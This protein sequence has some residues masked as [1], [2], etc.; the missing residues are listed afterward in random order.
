[1][2]PISEPSLTDR[3]RQY[4]LEAFD[5]GWISSRGEFVERAEALLRNATSARYAA[6]VSNGTVALHLA[7]LAAGVEAG[8]EV[9]MPSLSYV[10]TMNAA[11]YIGARPVLV[12]VDP[13]T[14]CVDP[15]AVAAAITDRTRAVIAV[16]LYGNPAD[17][18]A[19]R[20]VTASRGIVLI[21]D[22]AESIGGAMN[23]VPTGA[24]ADISIFSF[25]GN[26]IV[27]SGEGGAVTTDDPEIDARIRQLRNQ[28]NSVERRYFHDVLGFNYRM[29]NLAAAILCAQL[30]RLEE[31]TTHRRE[32]LDWYE[33]RLKGVAGVR[34]QSVAADV[35]RSPWLM[36][37]CVDDWSGAQRDQA[38]SLLA[39][40]GVET[41]PSFVP[42]QDMPYVKTPER[43]S[44]PISAKIGREG[45]SLPT[46]PG[47]TK[48]QVDHICERLLAAVRG[49][50]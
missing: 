18:A 3:E 46:F 36:T 44:T 15:H 5:S 19:L 34:L 49:L 8:D 33:S 40:E 42:M 17:Y 20:N 14:W 25:F 29:T 16:D 47:L 22:A 27:T 9:V 12:D 43:I 35:V 45:I 26:K 13:D 6:V 21:A 30:E 10:A 48:E 2:I 24:L 11:L 23:G 41:R 50:D 4:L 31:L 28:G 39:E 7:L 32:V 38:I 37:V 1:M